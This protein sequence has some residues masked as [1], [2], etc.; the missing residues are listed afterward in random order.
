MK[1][2]NHLFPFMLMF[3]IVFSLLGITSIN[4]TYSKTMD[5]DKKTFNIMIND[6]YA[7]NIDVINYNDSNILYTLLLDPSIK[8]Y[9]VSF[10]VYNEGNFNAK[11]NKI[12]FNELPE[13]LKDI[14][15]V[16]YEIKNTL[17]TNDTD[18]ETINYSLKDDLSYDELLLVDSYKSLGQTISLNYNQE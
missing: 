5:D 11:L 17:N 1:I 8:D 6:A 7:E 10:N 15:T 14:L 18:K 16:S 9:T 3:A 2:K 13:E 4:T 12:V